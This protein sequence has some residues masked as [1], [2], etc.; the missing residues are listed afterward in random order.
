MD[1]F[2]IKIIDDI[3]IKEHLWRWVQTE[4]TDVGSWKYLAWN[5]YINGPWTLVAVFLIKTIE[6]FVS[7]LGI[8]AVLFWE[9]LEDVPWKKFVFSYNLTSIRRLVGAWKSGRKNNENKSKIASCDIYC[10][11]KITDALRSSNKNQEIDK[12]FWNGSNNRIY[13][14]ST[15]LASLNMMFKPLIKSLVLLQKE[16]NT[17]TFHLALFL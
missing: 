4:K 1:K 3:S 8:W 11:I 6:N 5:L 2:T 12:A 17:L 10:K 14:Y 9:G 15:K 7:N 16:R 13:R